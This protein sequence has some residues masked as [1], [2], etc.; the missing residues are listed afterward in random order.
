MIPVDSFSR[1]IFYPITYI[2]SSFFTNHVP[3][4]LETG[5]DMDFN[6]DPV[7]MIFALPLQ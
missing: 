7:S 1:T 5:V 3:S 6:L 2:L 4:C